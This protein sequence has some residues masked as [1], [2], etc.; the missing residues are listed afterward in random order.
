MYA[1]NILRVVIFCYSINHSLTHLL[2]TLLSPHHLLLITTSTPQQFLR[3]LALNM[4][5]NVL[6]NTQT[7][8]S[9]PD[10]NQTME[11]M[12]GLRE[13][14]EKHLSEKLIGDRVAQFEADLAEQGVQVELRVRNPVVRAEIESVKQ[15][16][17]ALDT[18]RT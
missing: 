10:K 9:L 13:D 3:E 17:R 15:L 5:A 16:Q 8:D 12:R 18:D 6:T 2:I 7:Q 4:V 14:V 1:C 11:A